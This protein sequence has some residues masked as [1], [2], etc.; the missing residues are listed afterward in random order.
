MKNRKRS[1]RDGFTVLEMLISLF[2]IM[3]ILTVAIFSI[4]A[5][6]KERRLAHP[7]ME[8]KSFA[9]KAMKSSVA[10]QRSYSIYF[11]PN[12]FV[13]EETYPVLVEEDERQ[14]MGASL[15]EEEEDEEIS[16]ENMV[17]SL[18]HDMAE[19]VLLEVRHWN[20]K[21][22]ILSDPELPEEWVFT[23]SGLCEPL[24]VRF[25]IEGDYVEIDFNPLTG[26]VE[27]ERMYIQ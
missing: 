27:E 8:L 3:L 1:A 9:K 23:P 15:F 6:S 5:T 19:D 20:G 26:G 25:S 22:W 14:D 21:D 16:I 2:L 7:S 10:E 17:I 13:L 11:Y 12:A 24:S 18:R 4:G